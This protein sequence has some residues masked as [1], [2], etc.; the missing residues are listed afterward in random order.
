MP[1]AQWKCIHLYYPLHA[2]DHQSPNVF[3][4]W[5]WVFLVLMVASW[6][7]IRRGKGSKKLRL[8]VV[9]DHQQITSTFYKMKTRNSCQEQCRLWSWSTFG[10]YGNIVHW[11]LCPGLPLPPPSLHILNFMPDLTGLCKWLRLIFG[12]GQIAHADVFVL[13][14]HASL[15]SLWLNLASYKAMVILHS[16]RQI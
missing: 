2:L 14:F 9:R 3:L 4:F 8:W 16:T 15:P 1:I 11:L 13:G 5:H 12:Q 7:W 10:C 6:L